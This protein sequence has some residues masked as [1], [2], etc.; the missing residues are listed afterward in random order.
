MKL[1]SLG[2]IMQ[3]RGQH[4]DSCIVKKIDVKIGVVEHA[5]NNIGRAVETM[6]SSVKLQLNKFLQIDDEHRMT[7]T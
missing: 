3:Y 5:I 2:Y 1:T 4:D 7:A 6:T